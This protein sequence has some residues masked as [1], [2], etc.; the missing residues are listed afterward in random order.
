MYTDELRQKAEEFL[1]L[2]DAPPILVLPNAWDV[3]SARIFELEGFKAVGT[4]SAGIAA[5]LGYADGQRMAMEDTIE[6]VRRIAGRIRVPLSADM[7]AGYSTEIDG[8]VESARAVLD[9]GAVGLNLE[10]STLD[11]EA[12]LFDTSLQV[13]KISAIREMAS[14]VGVPLVV[15]ARTDG[16]L[17]LDD[18][19]A[20]LLKLT[21]ERANAYRQAGA[22]CIF[23]PDD[24]KLD[25]ETIARLV[26][27]IE[28]PV[29]VIAGARTPPLAELEAIG[30]ARVSLGPRPMRA[31]LALVR[32]IARELLE[33]GT[34]TRMTAETM[35]YSEV[36][37]MFEDDA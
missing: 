3:V 29:N 37:R 27:E 35:T 23:V 2:H 36:N 15:N 14:S 32:N 31:A 18:D 16:Y 10:D 11:P 21:V 6:V 19:P 22:D 12:P 25:K 9:A 34:Y 13:E 7:E 33:K 5:T 8:V 17:F 30:V 4:T 1:A 20:A 26:D 28:A 24:G